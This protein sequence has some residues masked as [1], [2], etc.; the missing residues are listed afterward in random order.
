MSV[1]KDYVTVSLAEKI[2]PLAL[3]NLVTDEMEKNFVP[4][5]GPVA[6]E[7][8]LAVLDQLPQFVKDTI[9]KKKLGEGTP[10]LF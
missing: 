3:A 4:M 7:L 5:S 1:R 10:C 9:K 6:R 2:D 8:W